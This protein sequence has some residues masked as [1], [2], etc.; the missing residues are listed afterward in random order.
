MVN[1]PTSLDALEALLAKA[2]PGEW[3]AAPFSSAVGCPITAQPDPK[4]NTVVLAGVHG[5]FRDDYAA[6]V[7]ANAA[8]IVAL[9]NA[10]PDLIAKARRAEELE[11]A[12]I[13]LRDDLLLRAQ[14]DIRD[15]AK[16]VNA[17][18]GVWR[19]F[20]AALKENTDATSD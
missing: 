11:A 3:K 10:A 7:Q 6:E 17:S 15:G 14:I 2:T 13:A 12:A 18:N 19:R 4:R 8:L 9:R 5:A 20:N 16:I 1:T